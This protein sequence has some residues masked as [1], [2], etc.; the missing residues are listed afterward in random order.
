MITFHNLKK[1][2][3]L[4]ELNMN[5][6]TLAEACCHVGQGWYNVLR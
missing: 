1:V 5:H 3:G 2:E 4:K 6:F